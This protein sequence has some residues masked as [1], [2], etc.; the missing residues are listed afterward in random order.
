LPRHSNRK[1]LPQD[2]Y[3]PAQ[4]DQV[5][6]VFQSDLLYDM[7]AVLTPESATARF[8]DLMLFG[9]HCCV[10]VFASQEATLKHLRSGGAWSSVCE[11]YL[12]MLG[13][14]MPLPTRA[15]KADEMD[16]FVA[17]ISGISRIRKRIIDTFTESSIALAE[18]L[19]NFPE[20]SDIDFAKP[21]PENMVFG[22]GTFYTPFSDVKAVTDATGATVV[23]GSKAKFRPRLQSVVTDAGRDGK[24]VRG[25]N[26][27]TI[28][29]WTASGWVVLSVAQA[30]KSETP[31]AVAMLRRLKK[32]IGEG[33]VWAVWDRAIRGKSWRSL[34][35]E[36]GLD[37]IGKESARSKAPAGEYVSHIPRERA[38]AMHESGQP[39]PLG[40]SVYPTSKNYDVTNSKFLRLGDLVQD[41][42]TH[43]L[44][45]DDAALFAVAR[46]ASSPAK[47]KVA[48]AIALR[49]TSRKSSRGQST[50]DAPTVTDGEAKEPGEARPQAGENWDDCWT[51][52]VDWTLAC[53]DHPGITHSFA[54]VW[55]P[56]ERQFFAEANEAEYSGTAL[57][58]L[59]S[60]S[61]SDQETF[62]AIH[63]FRN[64][65]EALHAW[66]KARLGTTKNRGRASRLDPNQQLIHHLGLCFLANAI[67]ERTAHFGVRFPPLQGN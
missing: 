40:V 17:K 1:Q 48:R 57:K 8:P 62:L 11:T 26:H 9:V 14:P 67:T 12:D 6:A 43:E 65:A 58:D 52:R 59:R 30:L 66:L 53:P 31:V 36:L 4:A 2:L 42:C 56:F 27:V 25:I 47:L 32:Q 34:K 38:I 45:V 35:D 7:S 13:R 3:A 39:L 15:P 29:T 49:E 22:D 24:G 19:G 20:L 50:G 64:I 44:Y 61:R 5:K 55:R 16:R 21:R 60:L 37:V 51:H 41:S 54:T 63:G 10:G 18:N 23:L 46:D 28:S 33:M